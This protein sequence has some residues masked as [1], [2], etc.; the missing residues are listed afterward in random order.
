MLFYM[1]CHQCYENQ[2]IVDNC[3]DNAL[4]LDTLCMCCCVYEM[5]ENGALP[6]RLGISVFGFVSQS[7]Y[8]VWEKSRKQKR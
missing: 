2:I 5:A 1:T 7:V 8:T 4:G 6:N 3:S